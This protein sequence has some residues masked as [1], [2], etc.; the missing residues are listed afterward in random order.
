MLS[1]IDTGYAYNKLKNI[2]TVF[3]NMKNLKAMTEAEGE[4]GIPLNRFKPPPPP[5]LPLRSILIL[6]VLRRYFCCGSFLLHVLVLAVRIYTL[7]QLL[8]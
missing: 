1:N 8:C 3:R 2:E 4:V 5:P 6:T 7:V